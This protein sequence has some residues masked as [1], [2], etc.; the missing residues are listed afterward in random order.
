MSPNFAESDRLGGTGPRKL[1]G[2]ALLRGMTVR[3]D[4]QGSN[5]GYPEEALGE[6]DS[7]EI[8]SS[9]DGDPMKMRTPVTTLLSFERRPKKK[10]EPQG[11]LRQLMTIL[12]DGETIQHNSFIMNEHEPIMQNQMSFQAVPGEEHPTFIQNYE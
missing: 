6:L 4:A 5:S 9:D 7:Q 11:E 2:L 3:P 1:S 10:P 12:E 8:S